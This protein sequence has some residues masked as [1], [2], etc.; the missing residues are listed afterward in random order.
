MMILPIMN[1]LIVF[2]S[3]TFDPMITKMI[4][5]IRSFDSAFW[6]RTAFFSRVAIITLMVISDYLLGDHFPGSDVLAFPINSSKDYLIELSALQKSLAT[7]T[8]WDSAHYLTIARDGK[9]MIDQHLAF[10]PFYPAVIQTT[11][12][13]LYFLCSLS[14]L[15]TH[16]FLSASQPI[17][18]GTY[19]FFSMAIEYRSISE[20]TT[21]EI[22]SEVLGLYLVFSAVLVSNFSFI[23]SVGILRQVLLRMVRESVFLSEL[24]SNIM[25]SVDK[26]GSS[27]VRSNKTNTGNIDTGHASYIK[28]DNRLVDVAVLCYICNP[29]TV[30]FASVYT[31]SMYS[32]LTFSGMWFLDLSLDSRINSEEIVPN[33]NILP[34]NV[35]DSTLNTTHNH[36]EEV[37]SLRSR[38][39]NQTILTL[40]A[41]TLRLRRA[42]LLITAAVCFFLSASTRSNGL[43]NTIFTLLFPFKAIPTSIFKVKENSQEI[44]HR[45]SANTVL[46]GSTIHNC[47]EET[48]S[49]S[50]SK[51]ETSRYE[52]AVNMLSHILCLIIISARMCFYTVLYGVLVFSTLGPYFIGNGHIRVLACRGIQNSNS[53]IRQALHSLSHN[54]HTQLNSH[55]QSETQSK[56]HSETLSETHSETQSQRRAVCVSHPESCFLNAPKILPTSSSSTLH[57][58]LPSTLLL[59]TP[60]YRQ[61]A[62]S[63]NCTQNPVPQIWNLRTF[64]SSFI[65][66]LSPAGHYYDQSTGIRSVSGHIGCGTDVSTASGVDP[67]PIIDSGPICRCL[68]RVMSGCG[69]VTA[70]GVCGSVGGDAGNDSGLSENENGN[71]GAQGDKKT[72]Q[73]TSE[74]HG[75]NHGNSIFNYCDIYSAVQRQY[76]NVGAFRYFQIKQIPNFLLAAPITI[77]SFFTVFSFSSRLLSNVRK[78]I[79]EKNAEEYRSKKRSLS[80][81]ISQCFCVCLSCLQS[82]LSSHLLHLLAVTVLGVVVAHVQIVT[83]LICSSCPVIYIGLAVLLT[84]SPR[85]NVAGRVLDTDRD[86]QRQSV[87]EHSE[88][89]LVIPKEHSQSGIKVQDPIISTEKS[90]D[91]N[92]PNCYVH[93]KSLPYCVIISYIILF[94]ILGIILHPNFYPWT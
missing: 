68:Y 71:C 66:Y 39:K 26:E 23:L 88:R 63:S 73:Y 61:C 12:V 53:D 24:N 52:S 30:F 58:T 80:S 17:L 28:R 7:F 74:E 35:T 83:R 77:I 22:P 94:N 56:T 10:Y 76:W 40:W 70:R 38:L 87:S 5:I 91:K 45:K 51:L 62:T 84:D 18:A 11:A 4:S 82:P 31:E 1:C 67:G 14:K 41:G 75:Q 85:L 86:N 8:K 64:V 32:L 34:S 78:K 37:F 36:H 19:A 50:K 69:G 93:S 13:I 42:T 59:T 72:R 47:G 60:S 57:S 6:F 79:T 20:F 15:C 46:K 33:K 89:S 43:L 81:S 16:F 65:R 9:Y 49:D 55:S 29:A 3:I 27:N 92:I 25:D 48:G 2:R 90:I 44:P 54:A 21:S